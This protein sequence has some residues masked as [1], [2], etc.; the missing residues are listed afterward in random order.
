MLWGLGAERTRQT[1]FGGMEV[2]KQW[3]EVRL[4]TGFAGAQRAARVRLMLSPS[5]WDEKTVPARIP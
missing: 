4:F 2:T 1:R 5:H 3:L